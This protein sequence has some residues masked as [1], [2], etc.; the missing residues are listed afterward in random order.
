MLERRKVVPAVEGDE[1][2]VGRGFP[3]AARADV[4]ERGVGGE[5][6][7]LRPGIAG[8]LADALQPHLESGLLLGAG[9]D[10][11]QVALDGR[12]RLGRA[13]DEGGDVALR[14][15]VGHHL[16]DAGPRR[17]GNARDSGNG[18]Q[19]RG[20]GGS[21]VH[22][23]YDVGDVPFAHRADDGICDVHVVAEQLLQVEVAGGGGLCRP[24]EEL[25]GPLL[26]VGIVHPVIDGVQRIEPVRLLGALDRGTEADEFVYRLF[27]GY[28]DEDVLLGARFLL[29]V[30]LQRV[31]HGDVVGTALRG[32]GRDD[33]CGQDHQDRAVEHAL[34]QQTDRLTVGRMAQDDVVAHHD[35][36][37]RGGHV[38]AAQSED[39]STLVLR[40]PEAL[41]R[42]PGGDEFRHGDQGDH[43][44]R[45]LEALPV[46]EEGTVVDEHAHADQ[47]EG[48]EDGVAD[49]LDAVHQR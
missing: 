43:D 28:G 47:E 23:Q 31:F 2:D 25:A 6:G 40:Q 14:Q 45:H 49:E 12:E 34:A 15:H 48:N 22:A 26:H 46:A 42:E 1:A 8:Q 18:G 9:R 37:E 7:H 21:L 19:R 11:D 3:F 38:G 16:S 20:A 10:D 29:I 5:E 30:R 4:L 17:A 41:L 35:G 36:G 32:E 27:V 24:V 33:A 44:G 39:D 13:V